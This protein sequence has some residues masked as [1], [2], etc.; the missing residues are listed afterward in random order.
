MQPHNYYRK[1]KWKLNTIYKKTNNMNLILS[2]ITQG[3]QGILENF[4]PPFILISPIFSYS[5]NSL[6]ISLGIT[7]FSFL[8]CLK[9]VF[10]ILF[11][12]LNICLIY[13]EYLDIKYKNKHYPDSHMKSGMTPEL[14]RIAKQVIM[15]VGLISGFITIKNEVNQ[16]SREEI[17]A[18]AAKLNSTL[19]QAAEDTKKAASQ[20]TS[21]NFIQKMNI[22][23]I[24]NSFTG[25]V[26]N[27]ETESALMKAI[28]ADRAQWEKSGDATLLE[29]IKRREIELQAT[30]VK[31]EREI[32]ELQQAIARANNFSKDISKETDDNKTSALI[33]DDEVKKSSILGLE[34]I[35]SRFETFDGL[36]KTACLMILSSSIVL[37][38]L[39]TIVITI[40]GDYLLDRFKLEEKYPKL[41]IFIKI[42]KKVS[43]YYI[44]SNIIHI[45]IVCLM[46]MFYGITILSLIYT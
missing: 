27:A 32:S 30:L 18:L 12:I 37:S 26:E 17:A 5:L 8:F 4:S 1:Q 39:L 24:Q 40:Y 42:R 36:T 19:A 45:L 35:W 28:K 13:T 31:K 34:E 14:Q 29:K 25:L 23:N 21:T 20:Q 43:K 41:A 22:T 6:W 10:F 33:N 38:S 15:T 11:I 16:S 7:E 44:L 3:L 9:V 46:N 2:N